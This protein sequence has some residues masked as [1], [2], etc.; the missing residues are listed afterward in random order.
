MRVAVDSLHRLLQ[1]PPPL[2]RHRARGARHDSPL[3]AAGDTSSPPA[4]CSSG[5]AAQT[6]GVAARRSG[7]RLHG[8]DGWVEQRPSR[9]LPMSGG[10]G[11]RDAISASNW[12]AVRGE[13]AGGDR[14]RRVARGDGDVVA[15]K[16]ASDTTLAGGENLNEKTRGGGGRRFRS[17]LVPVWQIFR[18]RHE[19]IGGRAAARA[20]A[21]ARG[22]G[23]RRRGRE[24]AAGARLKATRAGVAAC[25]GAKVRARRRR[26]LAEDLAVALGHL[27]RL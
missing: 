2:R 26:R 4:S 16:A 1:A 23:R 20:L 22:G 5:R 21:G 24:S 11:T 27:G 3:R 7:R 12:A 17:S 9:G 18:L 19:L 10:N 13:D 15:P 14:P 8:F 6:I 25:R